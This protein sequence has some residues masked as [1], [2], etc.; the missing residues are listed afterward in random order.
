MN[1]RHTKPEDLP[2]LL[3]L[4]AH[5]REF[6]AKTGNP[7]QWGD[8]LWPWPE[9]VEA[10]IKN[11][12]SYA[13]EEN[14]ELVGTFYLDYGDNPEPCYDVVE[15]GAWSVPGPYAVIHR[16]ASNGKRKGILEAAVR[17]ALTKTHQVRIDTHEDNVVM[18]NAL[19]KIGFQPIG[20]I[21][22]EHDVTRR[23]AFELIQE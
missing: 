1:I 10:D 5:A 17:F 2:A 14:G 18:Q 9:V 20:F 6:M 4:F 12:K 23:V 7:H 11:Q 15:H 16:I 21:Y 3:D 13:L 8:N 22:V 19:K